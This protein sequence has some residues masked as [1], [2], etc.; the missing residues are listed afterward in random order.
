MF[1]KSLDTV[2]HA[3][4][5]SFLNADRSTWRLLPYGLLCAFA[6]L[7]L[8]L[9]ASA[10]ATVLI[11]AGREE[12][13]RSCAPY[14]LFPGG[15]ALLV[16]AMLIG[17]DLFLLLPFK[18]QYRPEAC[19]DLPDPSI[20]AVLTA[21]NDELS[22]GDAV[23]DFLSSPFVRRVIVVD[24]GSSDRT[25]ECAREAGAKVAFEP[26][27]GYG[28]CVYRALLEGL[29]QPDTDL[30]MLC[31]GDR[32]F[33]ASDIP[34]F[35]AYL[36]HAEIVNGTRIIEQLRSRDT[37]LTMFMYYGNFVVGK[38]LEAKY[39]GQGTFTD[40]GT[41][42][43]LCRN[44]AL[45]RLLPHLNSSIDLEFNA[46]FLDTALRHRVALVECPVTFHKRVGVSKG[47]NA[48]NLRALLVGL[49]MIKGMLFSW[50]PG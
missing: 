46:H 26:H 17:T 13:I 1:S 34:K 4:T 47:G 11:I 20:T 9:L 27:R 49:R 41:T 15:A 25:A 32:T 42:Y 44:S 28:R 3:E 5:T 22:I 40:V 43:K 18:R 8:Y 37:Q 48:S 35:M 7:T 39:L 21:L 30:T 38:L 29:S 6:G 23:R 24:N 12:L 16:G 14:L 45:R 10:I 36:P 19:D 33:R 31:E 2:R 50:G